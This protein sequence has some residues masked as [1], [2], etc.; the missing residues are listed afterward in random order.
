MRRGAKKRTRSQSSGGRALAAKSSGL[1][2]GE[3]C[4][5]STKQR[6][7][8]AGAAGER[9]GEARRAGSQAA[10]R[11]AGKGGEGCWRR[12]SRGIRPASLS[13]CLGAPVPPCREH[14]GP[15]PPPSGPCVRHPPASPLPASRL[16]C[17]SSLGSSTPHP[18]VAPA[19]FSRPCLS[20]PVP[21]P[22][23][24]RGTR[25]TPARHSPSTP[26][27]YRRRPRRHPRRRQAGRSLRWCGTPPG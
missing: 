5:A 16:R 7:R 26:R 12:A 15:R 23:R 1:W 9:A 4:G 27:P 22:V 24:R 19:P 18:L 20:L 25:P 21:H 17:S 14:L 8:G 6:G 3:S 11:R 13:L 10:V 2:R